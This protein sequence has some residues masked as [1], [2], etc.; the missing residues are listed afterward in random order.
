MVAALLTGLVA[1]YLYPEGYYRFESADKPWPL[2]QRL[3]VF[4]F[5]L[6]VEE[7]ARTY[8]TREMR[9]WLVMWTLG[10]GWGIVVTRAWFCYKKTCRFSVE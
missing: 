4:V 9:L 2:W 5:L 1:R 8:M 6:S 3:T 10:A 7:A